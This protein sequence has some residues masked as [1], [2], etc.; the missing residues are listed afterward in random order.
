ML[1]LQ[2]DIIPWK[3]WS[4]KIHSGLKF[5]SE[6]ELVWRREEQSFP[7]PLIIV[8]TANVC[9]DIPTRVGFLFSCHSVFVGLVTILRRTIEQRLSDHPV[10]AVACRELQGKISRQ[11]CWKSHIH[12][13]SKQLKIKMAKM[14]CG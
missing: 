11:A 10:S 4:Y 8:T 2:W 14:N 6:E 9:V 7:C 13:Q 1:K 12:S 5:P 3:Q